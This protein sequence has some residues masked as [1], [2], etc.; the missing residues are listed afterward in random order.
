MRK[1]FAGNESTISVMGEIPPPPDK[2]PKDISLGRGKKTGVS[3]E[4]HY[5]RLIAISEGVRE[6]YERL[7]EQRTMLDLEMMVATTGRERRKPEFRN[8]FK[9]AGL[10]LTRVTALTPGAWCL[11]ARQG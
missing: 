8:L 11:E 2:L 3:I 5:R 1:Q 6:N 10:K 7:L 9:Q 4:E